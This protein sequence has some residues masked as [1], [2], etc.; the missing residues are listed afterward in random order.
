MLDDRIIPLIEQAQCLYYRLVLVVAPAGKGKTHLLR[1]VH[2]QTGASVVDVNLD[3]SRRM[4]DL[5]ER[6]RILQVP[7]LLA[8]ILS[9]QRGDVILLDNVEMLFDPALRQEPLRLLQSLA[10]DLTLVVAWSGRM[11]D[12]YLTYAI[13]DHPEYRRYEVRDF[14]MVNLEQCAPQDA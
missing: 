2:R 10:R 6:Q 14:L 1:E 4:L 7:V 12:G 9:T 13:P 11:I 5:T 8:E 3:L